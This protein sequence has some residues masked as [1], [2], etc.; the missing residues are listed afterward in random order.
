MKIKSYIF[1]FLKIKDVVNVPIYLLPRFILRDIF[2]F[3]IDF[4]D[5]NQI[6]SMLGVS[7]LVISK[8]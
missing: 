3:I 5:D 1:H 6:Y 2:N 7:K 8:K 4:L